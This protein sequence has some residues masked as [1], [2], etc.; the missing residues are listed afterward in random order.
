MSNADMELRAFIRAEYGANET[1]YM[2]CSIE[3]G[4]QRSAPKRGGRRRLLGSRREVTI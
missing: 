3:K 2:L 4:L 1:P